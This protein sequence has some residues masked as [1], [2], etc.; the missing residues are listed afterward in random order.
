MKTVALLLL[1]TGLLGCSQG[2][3]N[4]YDEPLNFICPV[5]YSIASI[6]SKHDNKREDRVWDLTC[7]ATYGQTGQCHWTSYV[8]DFDQVILFECPAQHVIAGISSY[9]SNP[10]EDRRWRFYCCQSVCTSASCHWTSYV[11]NF[12]EY[13]HYAVPSR[14]VL[15][16]AHSYHQNAQEDRRWAYRVCAQY[17]C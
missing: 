12:D 13:F 7:Q 9:H 10:H 14:N 8:N 4:N 1:L 3:Q 16:G 2:W 5:G 17:N 15:V 6:T 11:N